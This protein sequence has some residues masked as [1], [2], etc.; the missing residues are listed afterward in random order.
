MEILLRYRQ[1]FVKDDVL[2]GEWDI[3]GAEVFLCYSRF[4]I[5]GDFVIGRVECTLKYMFER[6]ICFFLKEFNFI[7]WFSPFDF[8]L[9]CISLSQAF[10]FLQSHFLAFFLSSA[11]AELIT[12]TPVCVC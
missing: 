3:F 1:L 9:Q 10:S 8:L 7:I 11:V 2:I 4:F 5:T 6:N 12:I